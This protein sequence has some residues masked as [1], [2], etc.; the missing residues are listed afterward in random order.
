MAVSNG[1]LTIEKQIGGDNYLFS[2]V[3][4]VA[5]GG[6]ITCAITSPAPAASVTQGV[7]VT[8]TGTISVAGT[9]VVKL[10]TTTLGNATM[11]G[12][13]W[14]YSWTPQLG[15]IG[16]QTL[17][18]V[19]TATSGGATANAPGVAVTVTSLSLVSVFTTTPPL[20]FHQSNLG[21]TPASWADQGPANKPA[22]Q[23]TGSKQPT[24]S[25]G[26][27]G[28]AGVLTDGV[29]DFL[30]VAVNAA[31]PTVGTPLF[32]LTIHRVVSAPGGLGTITGSAG[33]TMLTYL[34]AGGKTAV[35]FN[36][37][38]ANK[39]FVSETDD[40]VC[41]QELYTGTAA[42]YRIVGAEKVT[43]GNAGAGGAGTG[44]YLGG[45]PAGSD[46]ANLE[47]LIWGEFAAEPTP[48][49]L[50]NFFA[51][52]K[53]LYGTANVIY[54]DYAVNR[55]T[56]NAS[57]LTSLSTVNF[58]SSVSA[59]APQLAVGK[60]VVMLARA[61]INA[62]I[63]EYGDGSTRGWSIGLSN[64]N[65]PI[66][67]F[68]GS[69][70]V[71][72]VQFS[73][74][75][76]LQGVALAF[77]A[78]GAGGM[79]CSVNGYDATTAT[80]PATVAANA[81]DTFKLGKASDGTG[82]ASELYL[83]AVF[84]RVLSDAELKQFSALAIADDRYSGF[85]A[86]AAD[87]ACTF[88]WSTLDWD[89]AAST[90]LSRGS[91]PITLTKQGSPVKTSFTEVRR[92]IT[93]FEMSD[94]VS[95]GNTGTGLTAKRIDSS[96]GQL[97][98]ITGGPMLDLDVGGN[99][100]NFSADWYLNG[101]FNASPGAGIG[102]LNDGTRHV[103]TPGVTAGNKYDWVDSSVYSVANEVSMLQA[104]RYRADAPAGIIRKNTTRRLVA[105]TD[106]IGVS[107]GASVARNGFMRLIRADYPGRVTV[108]GYGSRDIMLND[109]DLTALAQHM[110]LQLAQGSPTTKE[111]ILQICVNTALN[112]TGTGAQFQAR[113]LALVD[114]LVANVSG[115]T[116]IYIPKMPKVSPSET[117]GV[118][119]L[120]T[121][122]RA[123][124]VAVVAA[125]SAICT[126]VDQTATLTGG[127]PSGGGPHPGDTGHAA[128]KASY[129]TAIGY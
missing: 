60:S 100:Q 66:V 48:T 30:A 104:I 38:N 128:L 39:N 106:S 31:N 79:H 87:G 76:Q 27:N 50:A 16:A 33:T 121:D 36:G 115:L 46:N 89:G 110:A 95:T 118:A 123:A 114:A 120:A 52:A 15:D 78:T 73:L 80:M 116:R 77:A 56:Y 82:V 117:I 55:A 62:F 37:A 63:A 53:A 54:P 81:G 83:F 17:N 45:T 10:G 13:N 12:L 124:Q 19:A 34:L 5:L 59:S 6:A 32:V 24:A 75:T 42:D 21:F 113:L 85:E 97:K 11:A 1:I 47:V 102:L 58:F 51:A 96:F 101:A 14:S 72:P 57:A 29:D 44:R 41:T 28:V 65:Q 70:A 25:A 4:S 107:V 7:P 126:L 129:K 23:A 67:T 108:E 127:E 61:P 68:R 22:T 98:L 93:D 74:Q 111:V 26:V 122:I 92:T 88:Y 119:G 91:V 20:H 99:A 71:Q 43:G 49:E 125:R 94:S 84:N 112:A 64:G 69:A 90:S 35:Q 8:I 86:L 3:N 105:Y 2:L 9:V 18:A 109:L 40:F 103:W